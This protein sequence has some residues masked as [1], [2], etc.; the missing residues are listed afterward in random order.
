[1]YAAKI[2]RKSEHKTSQWSGGTTTQLLIYPED[3]EYSERNF[4]WRLSSAKVEV[5]KSTFTHLDGISRILMIID[6]EIRLEHQGHHS[7][8]LKPFE[9]DSFKGDW[10]TISFGK[11]TDFNLMMSEGCIGK[12]EALLLQGKHIVKIPLNKIKENY[13]C[14]TEVFYAAKGNISLR[15]SNQNEQIDLNEGDLISIVKVSDKDKHEIEMWTR[16][17]KSAV[18]RST[19]YY[20]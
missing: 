18:I 6:G 14:V 12:L 2:I 16:G 5:E 11:V 9:Q 13:K 8:I 7:I 1:M 10:T 19:I 20:Q 15:T 17:G 3:S 4:K